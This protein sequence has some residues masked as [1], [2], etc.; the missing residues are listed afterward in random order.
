MKTNAVW[1]LLTALSLLACETE[2]NMNENDQ[3][4]LRLTSEIAVQTRAGNADVPDKQIA[5]QQQVGVFI[6]NTSGGIIGKNLK[7][8]ADGNGGLAL[9]DEEEQPYYPANG[10]NVRIYAYHPYTAV[11]DAGTFDFSVEEDQNEETAYYSSDLLYS[12]SREYPCSPT[13]HS[14]LFTHKLSKVVCILKSD[15]S[16]LPIEEATIEIVGAKVGGTFNLSDGTFT[17]SEDPDSSADVRMNN[18]IASGSYIAVIP[19]LSFEEGKPFLKITMND[20]ELLYA[21]D[22]RLELQSGNVYTYTITVRRP[23]VTVTSSIASWGTM[24][25]TSGNAYMD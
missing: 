23:G 15:D 18:T 9:A 8:T 21:S 10:N 6:S 24:G 11:S 3:V 12:E 13:A 20:K 7:Y 1:A 2:N 22:E 5:E 25:E 4:E 14:L 19:P 17:G 16:D